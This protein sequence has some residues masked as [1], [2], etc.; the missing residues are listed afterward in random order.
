[1]FKKLS[2]FVFSLMLF[3][4]LIQPV[5]AQNLGM[6]FATNFGLQNS[7]QSDPR[8]MAVDIVKYLMTFLGIIA[9]AV[10]LYGGFIWMTASGNDDKIDKAKKLIIAGAIG[11]IIILAAFA[12]VQFV[13]TMSGNA[14]S[15]DF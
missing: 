9:V 10:I 2:I 11:L 15:G 14:L 7:A 6:E 5:L 4:I 12:I 13:V 1:M 8:D 3:F